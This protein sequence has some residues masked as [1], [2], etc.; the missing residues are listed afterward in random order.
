MK[1]SFL[2]FLL[3]LHIRS[4][5]FYQKIDKLPDFVEVPLF[6]LVFVLCLSI[7]NFCGFL[8]SAFLFSLFLD[9]CFFFKTYHLFF[10]GIMFLFCVFGRGE[11]AAAGQQKLGSVFLRL[12]YFIFWE[13]PGTTR[14]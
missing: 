6:V 7:P 12:L 3:F 14:K 11:V 13:L 9:S 5:G 1:P 2:S 8:F 10:V 4:S